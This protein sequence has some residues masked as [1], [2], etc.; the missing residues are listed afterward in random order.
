VFSLLA[1]AGLSVAVLTD[2]VSIFPISIQSPFMELNSFSVMKLPAFNLS[3]Q[4]IVSLHSFCA[5]L[6][7]HIKSFF[8]AA[9]P[10][11]ATLAP[12]LVP[13]RAICLEKMNSFFVSVRYLYSFAILSANFPL[14]SR[15]TLSIHLIH[16]F[17]KH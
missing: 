9:N 2:V 13:E 8:E 1:G 17:T 11:S 7:L 14:L 15:K 16:Y 6:S 4:Y 3:S 10:A 12:I 5:I